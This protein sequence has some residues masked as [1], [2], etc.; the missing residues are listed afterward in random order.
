MAK[1]LSFSKNAAAVAVTLI[2]SL[3]IAAVLGIL[4]FADTKGIRAGL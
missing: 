1:V 2:C 4:A 3:L